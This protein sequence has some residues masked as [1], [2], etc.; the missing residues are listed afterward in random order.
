MCDVCGKS[1]MHGNKVSDSY[2][3]TRRTWRPNLHKIKAVVEGTTR[4]INICT[5]CLRSDFVQ[6]KVSMPKDVRKSL[7]EKKSKLVGAMAN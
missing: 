2:N 5:S 4:T 6:K 1:P 7:E 3:H